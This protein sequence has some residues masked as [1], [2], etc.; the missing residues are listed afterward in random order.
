MKVFMTSEP[1]GHCVPDGLKQNFYFL[2][3]DNN[4]VLRRSQKKKA[5][6][7]DDCGAWDK[8][9]SS[10]T[11]TY[12]INNGMKLTYIEKS[13]GQYYKNK[14]KGETVLFP[15]PAED[16]IITFRRY[17]SSLKADKT[18]KKRITN[19]IQCPESMNELLAIYEY[20][21]RHPGQPQPHGN[22]KKCD[23]MY[24]RTSENTHNKIKKMVSTTAPREVYQ[25]LVLNGSQCAPRDLKQVQNA[26]YSESAK[27]HPDQ[28]R[29]NAAD[30][31][32]TLINL[33][34]DSDFIQEILHTKGKPPSVILYF[35]EQL[36]DIAKFCSSTAPHPSVLG[37]DRTFNL[38]PCYVTTTVY[39]N[40]NLMRKGSDLRPASC[41]DPCSY[42]GTVYLQR[43]IGF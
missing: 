11:H 19:I 28:R 41:L 12:L 14:K 5:K 40:T 35:E 16:T 18:F 8:K 26:K 29:K 36:K 7:I 17:Y 2:L 1:S 37:I 15:Q 13:N 21:G 9:A 3:N 24:I 39:H 31:I 32:Q 20:I 25:E 22:S 34:Q 30:D 6:Y 43:T 27:L 42:I 33:F 10:N 23:Q 38:G 4:N